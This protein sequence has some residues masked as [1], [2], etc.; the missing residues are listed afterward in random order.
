MSEVASVK[1][2]DPH[3]VKTI[4]RE[5]LR[6]RLATSTKAAGQLIL[7]RAAQIEMTTPTPSESDAEPAAT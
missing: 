7:E 2:T 3:V 6:R 4:V 1:I 5:Q